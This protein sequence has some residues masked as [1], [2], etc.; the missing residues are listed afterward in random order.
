VW[1]DFCCLQRR[2]ALRHSQTGLSDLSF[3]DRLLCL[4]CSSLVS[5][6]LFACLWCSQG[7]QADAVSTLASAMSSVIASVGRPLRGFAFLGPRGLFDALGP[8]SVGV[9]RDVAN[10]RNNSKPG[11]G[12]AGSARQPSA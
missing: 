8:R 3:H 5:C 4:A 10:E 2:L 6:L 7:K 11:N 9:G 12:T 1:A